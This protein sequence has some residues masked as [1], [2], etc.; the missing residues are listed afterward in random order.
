MAPAWGPKADL[1][2]HFGCLRVVFGVPGGQILMSKVAQA[3]PRVANSYQKSAQRGPRDVP[4]G[5]KTTKNKKLRHLDFERP[6]EVLATFSAF[7]GTGAGKDG[8]EMRTLRNITK[9]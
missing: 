9:K 8:A 4:K 6:Y 5:R 2:D 1:G 7:G 3:N